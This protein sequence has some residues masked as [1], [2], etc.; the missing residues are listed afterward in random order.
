M[1]RPSGASA[2]LYRAL[3]YCPLVIANTESDGKNA[4]LGLFRQSPPP[5]YPIGRR[6]MVH[7][8]L[9]GTE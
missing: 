1:M 5:D 4:A 8:A 7:K 3:T 9:S 2:A 6:V